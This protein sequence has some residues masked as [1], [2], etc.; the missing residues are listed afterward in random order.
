MNSIQLSRKT[1]PLVQDFLLILYIQP[2]SDCIVTFEHIHLDLP[3]FLEQA[4]T[5]YCDTLVPAR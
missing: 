5:C 2:A 1:I 4:V 3:A